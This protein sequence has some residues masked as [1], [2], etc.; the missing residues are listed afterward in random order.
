MYVSSSLRESAN[1]FESRPT[2]G[3]Q[4]VIADYAMIGDGNSAGLVDRCGA[5]PW[6]CW[7]RFDSQAIFAAMLG[8]S[9]NGV[10]SISPAAP[11]RVTRRY[12]LDT[13]I[14]ETRFDTASGA[15][16]LT[17]FMPYQ[18]GPQAVIRRVRGLSGAIPMATRFAPRFRCGSEMPRYEK[19]VGR[20]IACS[21]DVSVAL[22]VTRAELARGEDEI[23]FALAEGQTVDFVLNSKDAAPVD[24][25]AYVASAQA[26]CEAFWRAWVS[27]CTYDGPWRDVVTRS[28]ITLKALIY[29]PSGGIVAAPTASLPEHVGGVRNW[30]YRYCWL[31]DSTFTVLALLHAGYLEEASAW[32][33]WLIRAIDPEKER[34]KV[35]YG[36]VPN[37]EVDEYEA[38]WLKGFNASRP[39]RF[40]NGARTQLQLGVYGEVQDTLHQWRLASGKAERDGWAQ[41][42]A[43]LTR[44]GSLA[45]EPDAGI[46][47][48]RGH[49]ERF[50]LSRALAW[51]AFDRALRT[52]DRFAFAKDPAWARHCEA[53]RAEICEQ[54]YDPKLEAFTRAYG[55]RSLDA[56]CLLLAMVGFLPAEDPRIVGT[57]RAIRSRLSV[58]PFVYRYDAQ[59][60][61]D[62]VGGS[63][64]AFLACSFWLADNLVLQKREDDAAAIFESVVAA[65]NDVGLL[66]EEYDVSGRLLLG[67]FPQVL[68]HLSLVHTALNLTGNGP[69]H[70]RS[71]A[72][73]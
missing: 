72:A 64:G 5:I 43:T 65:A 26:A 2:V 7:P 3:A 52:A 35:F 41:Q 9:D 28:L 60:E 38:G 42:C 70:S 50:T 30:D 11:N 17:D 59:R 10:W 12:C 19:K 53:L 40:G 24:I 67:N 48:Q 29:S 45:S 46:W 31:R 44:L 71:K 36:V 6:L 63:E 73:Y 56:S 66:S 23:S 33:N 39:V 47:E 18:D 49:L 55:S 34:T 32:V 13:L 54:G 69:V 22:S 51:V 58:G 61:H 27:R 20:L 14:L 25:P 37:T 8:D 15:A 57:V 62:G 1:F 68:T 21:G 4:K 16:L